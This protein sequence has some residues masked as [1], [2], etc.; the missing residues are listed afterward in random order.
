MADEILSPLPDS[1]PS[2]FARLLKHTSIV[3]GHGRSPEPLPLATASRPRPADLPICSE[4]C[5][6]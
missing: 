4:P 5:W 6:A 2:L 3:P 1:D